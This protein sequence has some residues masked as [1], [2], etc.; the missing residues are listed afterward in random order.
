MSVAPVLVIGMH[1]SGTSLVTRLLEDLGLFLGHRKDPNDEAVFFQELNRW[2]LRQCGG[3]WDHPHAVDALLDHARAFDLTA[4]YLG[5]LA[6]SPR[7]VR[8][9]GWRRFLRGERPGAMPQAWGW[10]DPRTTFTLPLWQATFPEARV[11]HIYRHGLDVARSLATRSQAQLAWSAARH[12]KRKRLYWLRPKQE[13][14]VDSVNCLDLARGLALWDAYV[15]RA[16]QHVGR[17]GPARAFQVQ[18]EELARDPVPHLEAL[19]AFCGL[20]PD[21]DAIAACARRIDPS[22]AFG[23]RRAEAKRADDAWPAGA[24]S[25]LAAHG[26]SL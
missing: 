18:F 24:A 10:K 19:V 20:A 8:F 7:A 21:A 17:L 3:A 5:H 22:R 6:R 25:T 4:D 9:L 26:Y 14:F 11:V 12:P 13:G 16:R 1:R 15:T 23:Y 2:V